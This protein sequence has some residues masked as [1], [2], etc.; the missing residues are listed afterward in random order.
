[1]T[2]DIPR[3]ANSQSRRELSA[4][5]DRSSPDLDH[6][7]QYGNCQTYKESHVIYTYMS[8]YIQQYLLQPCGRL[9]DDWNEGLNR[10][11]EGIKLEIKS[12]LTLGSVCPV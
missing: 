4:A 7:N 5:A 3:E 2:R 6:N 12:I 11:I 9:V 8:N 10:H 1:M